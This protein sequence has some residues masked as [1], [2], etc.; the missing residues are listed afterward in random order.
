MFKTTL[1]PGPR[2]DVAY[3]QH[4]IGYAVDDSLPNPL[5]AFFAALAACA[6]VFAKKACRRLGVSEAGIAIDVK[7]V[8]RADN[9]LFPE[10]FVTEV[11]FPAQIDAA[12][13]EAILA[14]ISRCAVK[15]LVRNG[16]Q[17]DFS[18]VAVS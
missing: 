10:K 7:P 16:A 13:R 11:R 2:I 6:G 15:E 9:P 17:I 8:V 3:R 18:V 12:A 14:E 4:T 5:E 1:T